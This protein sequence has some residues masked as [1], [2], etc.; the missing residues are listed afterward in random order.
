[1]M[2]EWIDKKDGYVIHIKGEKIDGNQRII[3]S[4]SERSVIKD[5]R[6]QGTIEDAHFYAMGFIDGDSECQK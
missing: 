5:C 2:G 1:M 4:H 6:I 3:I